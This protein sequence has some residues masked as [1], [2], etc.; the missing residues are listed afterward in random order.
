MPTIKIKD[1]ILVIISIIILVIFNTW[2]NFIYECKPSIETGCHQQ[3]P[4]P[5]DIATPATQKPTTKATTIYD[6]LNSYPKYGCVKIPGTSFYSC[7]P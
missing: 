2:F 5:T 4:I 1:S 6:P 3:T 7:P